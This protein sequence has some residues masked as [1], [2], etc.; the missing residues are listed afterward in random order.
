MVEGKNISMLN[1]RLKYYLIFFLFFG[2]GSSAFS[3]SVNVTGKVFDNKSSETM[4]GSTVMLLN[5]SD[6]S[7][8]KF[9]T[10][11]TEGIFSIKGAKAGKYLLQISFIGYDSYYKDL[12][13]TDDKK[14]VD[15]GNLRLKTKQALLKTFEVVEE[16]VPVIINGDTVEFNSAAFKTQ[17][18]DNV[19]K[20]L[21]KLPG[22]EVD[23]DGKI[24]AQG[25]EVKKVLIDGKEFFGD[26]TKTATENLPAD[27]V[28]SVQVYDEFSD[29][30]KINPSSF[31]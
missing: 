28:K 6:S 25:E 4:P 20:L 26:D 10:T 15:L 3:Q 22:V 13:L 30:S 17:P 2:I 11:N 31:S 16:I 7:F 18:E 19:A 14:K 5:P 23:A 21:K 29:A 9:S 1:M 27:M 24:Q 12:T 8:Y